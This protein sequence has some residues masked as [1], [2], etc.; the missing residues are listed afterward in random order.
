MVFVEIPVSLIQID[1]ITMSERRGIG[2]VFE[3]KWQE[4]AWMVHHQNEMTEK[5]GFG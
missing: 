1:K 5:Q 4:S 3:R 2:V